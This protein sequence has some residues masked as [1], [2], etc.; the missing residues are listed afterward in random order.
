MQINKALLEAVDRLYN[1]PEFRY[2]RLWLQEQSSRTVEE[3][4]KTNEHPEL[5][6]GRARAMMD[7]VRIIETAPDEL[8][9]LENRANGTQKSRT[10]GYPGRSH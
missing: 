6:R 5:H 3:A 4:I 7:L 2:L 8:K 9:R 10:T 1:T